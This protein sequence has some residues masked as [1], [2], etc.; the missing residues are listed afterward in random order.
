MD[1]VLTHTEENYL[2]ALFKANEKQKAA[3]NTNALA[4]QMKTSAASVTDMLK[5]LAQK[6]LIIY[7]RYRGA[8]LSTIG[9]KTATEVI[10]RHRLWETFL[11]DKLGFSWSDVHEIAEELEH[12]QSEELISRLDEY[13]GYPKYDPHGDPIPSADGKFTLREQYTLSSLTKDQTGIIIGVKNHEK[14][15]LEYLNELD[16][17]LGTQLKVLKINDYDQSMRLLL[18]QREVTLSFRVTQHLIVGK[19]L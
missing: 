11:V 14:S 1:T 15:Y 17:A 2:K 7:E 9:T 5:K 6:D 16:I 13:L 12:I 10:R 3:V 18:H 4:D 8:R 19:I